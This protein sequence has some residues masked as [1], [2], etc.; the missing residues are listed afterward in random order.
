MPEGKIL[1][2]DDKPAL[3]RCF[4]ELCEANGYRADCA[5][6]G[7]EALR[8]IETGAYDLLI[9]DYRMPVMNGLEFVQ[10]IRANESD[11]PIIAMSSCDLEHLFITAGADFFLRKPF[12]PDILE[13]KIKS[14][15]SISSGLQKRI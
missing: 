12:G 6:N 8:C 15:C 11:I 1:I 3:R 5:S 10:K 4:K 13:E 14:F 2:V 7:E 9:V